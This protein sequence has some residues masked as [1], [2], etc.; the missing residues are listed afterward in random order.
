ISVIP[1]W[2]DDAAIVPIDGS[3]NPL[4][5]EWALN[6]K[7]VVAY[8]GNLG[9]AHDVETLL[10]AAERLNARTDVIFLFSG[11]GHGIADLGAEVCK[12]KLTNV[13]FK[14]YQPRDLLPQSLGVGDVHWLSLKTGLDGLILPSKFYG[15]AAAGRPIIVI[16]SL[17]GELS[18]LVSQSDCGFRVGLGQCDDLARVII[19]LEADRPRCRQMGLNARRLLDERFTKAEALER[20]QAVLQTVAG[21]APAQSPRGG[22]FGEVDAPAAASSDPP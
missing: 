6:N 10:G 14:P 20:W 2:V 15:I 9:R 13:L 4:R 8:S 18:R 22:H 19:A 1:N 12:R 5:H 11:S 3:A 21:V 7:F 16:G 17:D